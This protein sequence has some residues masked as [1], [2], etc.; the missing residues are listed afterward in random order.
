M[1]KRAKLLFERALISLDKDKHFWISY[2][3]FIDR[4]LKDP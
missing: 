1:L 3:Q 4:N 2:V